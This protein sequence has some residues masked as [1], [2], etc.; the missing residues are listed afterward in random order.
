MASSLGAKRV[1]PMDERDESSKTTSDEREVTLRRRNW[2]AADVDWMRRTGVA[3]CA[4]AFIPVMTRS[5][6]ECC[7]EGSTLELVHLVFIWS[8]GSVASASV[9]KGAVQDGRSW[10]ANDE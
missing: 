2:M 6:G 3:A 9:A 10:R 1:V 4:V 8:A 7:T 5:R